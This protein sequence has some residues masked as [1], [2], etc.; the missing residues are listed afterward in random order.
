M[1]LFTK[2]IVSILIYITVTSVFLPFIDDKTKY[3][4]CGNYPD[5]HIFIII[6][7][8][9][10]CYLFLNKLRK[11]RKNGY[12]KFRLVLLERHKEFPFLI[13]ENDNEYYKEV[14]QLKRRIAL[15]KINRRRWL[16]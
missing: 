1:E 4:P 8:G 14:K 13:S 11:W 6:L 16:H 5:G 2:I 12:Y 7:F 10:F 9:P 15:N 3:N